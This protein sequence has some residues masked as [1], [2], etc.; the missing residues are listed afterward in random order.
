MEVFLTNAGLLVMNS[1]PEPQF[2][3]RTSTRAVRSQFEHSCRCLRLAA[4]STTYTGP[5]VANLLG[6]LWQERDP[7]GGRASYPEVKLHLYGSRNHARE[8]EGNL[9]APPH[10]QAAAELVRRRVALVE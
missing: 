3:H 7:L 1:R 4:G 10:R 5:R 2:R 8:E 6:D 9:T